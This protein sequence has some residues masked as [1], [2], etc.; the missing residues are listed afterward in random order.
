MNWSVPKFGFLELSLQNY[1]VFVQKVSLTAYLWPHLDRGR[2]HKL[3]SFYTFWR[4]LDR[5]DAKAKVVF[6]VAKVVV[7][8]YQ[9]VLL[10]QEK[11]ALW[12]WECSVHAGSVSFHML[13][14]AWPVPNWWLIWRVCPAPQARGEIAEGGG[15]GEGGEWEGGVET[16][17][18]RPV[19]GWSEVVVVAGLV[20]LLPP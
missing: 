8:P 6:F 11:P 2:T 14:L 20:Q 1:W 19:M 7:R 9:S 16:V 12:Q 18:L 15:G 4:L 3:N 10:C 13:T 5:M 17:R